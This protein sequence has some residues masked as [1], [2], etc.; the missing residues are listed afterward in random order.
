MSLLSTSNIVKIKLYY[1][2]KKLSSGAEKI[3]IFEDDEAKKLME[4]EDEAI[5][6]RVQ[7]LNTGWRSL[8]WKEQNDITKESMYYDHN[9]GMQD[10]DYFSYRDQRIKKCL[11]SWDL[12]DDQGRPQPCDAERIDQLP[13]EV[14]FALVNKYDSAVTLDE[15]ERGK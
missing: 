10:V 3:I 9:Q 6:K 11:K 1:E 4:S 2:I 14:V 5:K 7:V 8:T 15:E 13:A 12:K